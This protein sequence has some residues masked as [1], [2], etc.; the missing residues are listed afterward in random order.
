ME[1]IGEVDSRIILFNRTVISAGCLIC[2][3]GDFVCMERKIFERVG[4]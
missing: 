3:C 2:V 4:N 1:G